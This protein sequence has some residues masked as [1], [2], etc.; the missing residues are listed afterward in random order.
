[1]RLQTVTAGSGQGVTADSDQGVDPTGQA[2]GT[3]GGVGTALDLPSGSVQWTVALLIS[4]ACSDQEVWEQMPSSQ[5]I[6]RQ[7]PQIAP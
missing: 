7:S 4:A 5:A 6:P 2:P 3:P 1:M